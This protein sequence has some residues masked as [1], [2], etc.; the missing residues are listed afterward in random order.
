MKFLKNIVF[1]SCLSILGCATDSPE[2][3]WEAQN[4]NGEIKSIAECAYPATL[5]FGKPEKKYG[6]TRCDS[7]KFS[8]NGAI[9]ESVILKTNGLLSKK[10]IYKYDENSM[11][12]EISQYD[13]FGKLTS[14]SIP[15]YDNNG[16][17]I[18]SN[19]YHPDGSFS[20]RTV[21]KYDQRGNAIEEFDERSDGSIGWKN[22]RTF[23]DE[24]HCVTL[25]VYDEVEDQKKSFSV[26][27]KYNENG[28]LI[29]TTFVDGDVGKWYYTYTYEYDHMDNWIISFEFKN[30]GAVDEVPAYIVE[31]KIEYYK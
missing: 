27:Y 20:R 24:G 21:Y 1:I 30:S 6:D 29:K 17:R 14:K 26:A 4:L 2:S 25:D 19:H 31:R 11:L 12:S 16:Q 15:N 18:E 8:K 13:E 23:D 3:D 28:N 10:S 5:S 9:L 22:I 7:T